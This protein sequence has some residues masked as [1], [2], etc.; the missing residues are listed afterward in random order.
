VET[1]H[2]HKTFIIIISLLLIFF[3]INNSSSAEERPLIKSFEIRGNKRMEKETIYARI[4]SRVG[5]YLSQENVQRDIKELYGLGYFDDVRVEVE[6]FEGGVKIIFIVK[7]KPTVVN[8]DFQGNKKFKSEELKEKITITPGAI[9]A[10]SLIMDNIQRIISFYQSEGYWQVRVLPIIRY[11]SDESVILTFQIDEGLKVKVKKIIIEGNSSISSDD[12]KDVMETKEWWIFSFITG[13]GVYREDEVKRDMGR[14]R[15]LYH[16]KGYIYMKI[17]EPEITLSPDKKNIFLKISISEGDQYKVGEVSFSGNTVFKNTEFYKH[18]KTAPGEIFDRTAIREDI[19]NIIDLYM[20]KGYARADVNPLMSVNT[21]ERYVDITFSITEGDIYRIGRIQITGNTK[22]RDKVIRREMRFDEGDVFNNKLIKRSYQRITNLDYFET[23]EINTRP[24]INEKLIDID[25]NV[26][27][28]LTGML[29]V[30]AGYSSID[31]LVVMGEIIQRNLFGKGYYLKLKADLSSIRSDYNITFAN[32]WF[33]DKPISASFSLYNETFEYPD[34]DKR[35]TG[36]SI[37]FGKELSEYVRGRITYNLESVTISNV[38]DDASLIIKEQ[39]GKKI[40]S[41][42]SPSIWRDS[43]DNFLDP[44]TGS[45]NALYTTIAGL[46]GDNY[47]VKGVID[48]LWYFPVGWNTTISF[49]GRIGYAR[50]YAGEELP[51]YERFYVGGIN[52]VRGL[53][54]GEGGPRDEEGEKI[55][56]NK[57]L[58]FNTEYIFPIE[59]AIRLKGVIFFDAGKAFDDGEPID[60]TSLRTTTGFGLRWI[61]P[62]GPIRL[63]WGFNLDPE[64]DEGRSK[65][66]F[67]LGGLF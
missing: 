37:G 3:N 56:G 20:E 41:S 14:I 61:S 34:Y 53:G 65:I 36:G 46:G 64:P 4:K 11:I 25:I 55:G 52:T 31:K 30:G 42:I 48:S 29:T 59:K 38:E 15:E 33:M 32:P 45:K 18:I 62:F 24:R 66:E 19:D 57:E 44:T 27:E 12:I 10:H 63:E 1:L 22:T 9:A 26:K 50:G 28:K 6:P 16:S 13:S 58:I 23:V 49:R 40:T 17:S 21:E 2:L 47:F 60:I 39:I 51:L 43:R 8:I 54:F 35:A 7:E 67:T 5:T